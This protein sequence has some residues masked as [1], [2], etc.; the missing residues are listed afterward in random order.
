[1]LARNPLQTI[2][3]IQSDNNVKALSLGNGDE[4]EKSY[5]DFLLHMISPT[6]FLSTT[7]ALT[8]PVYTSYCPT[9]GIPASK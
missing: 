1:L 2:T 8:H 4:S 3:I 9:E 6:T 5:L 7:K